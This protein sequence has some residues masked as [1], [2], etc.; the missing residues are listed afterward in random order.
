LQP[1]GKNQLCHAWRFGRRYL[2]HNNG[3]DEGGDSGGPPDPPEE[4]IEGVLRERLGA[5]TVVRPDPPIFRHS[6][7]W[8]L[9]TAGLGL[10]ALLNAFGLAVGDGGSKHTI[11]A[12]LIV[13]ALLAVCGAAYAGILLRRRQMTLTGFASAGSVLLLNVLVLGLTAGLAALIFWY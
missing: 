6:A 13:A 3:G 9:G 11:V 7:G 4:F 10:G 8:S 12:A 2:R 1:P 5:V